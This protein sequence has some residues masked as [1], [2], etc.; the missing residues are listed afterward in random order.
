MDPGIESRNPSIGPLLSLLPYEILV[1]EV[2]GRL[3]I[4]DLAIAS[5]AC[6]KLNTLCQDNK[7]WIPIVLKNVE[8]ELIPI[9]ILK[10]RSF[11]KDF[12]T[13]NP[14]R[15]AV[16]AYELFH[17]VINK[18]LIPDR[19]FIPGEANF[20]LARYMLKHVE[21]FAQRLNINT[22]SHVP[23][24]KAFFSAN[25]SEFNMNDE[26]SFPA[27]IFWIA[28]AIMNY[29]QIAQ[30][31]V[32]ARNNAISSDLKA[33]AHNMYAKFNDLLLE[34]RKEP[35]CID[36]KEEIPEAANKQTVDDE[37]EPDD[38]KLEMVPQEDQLVENEQNPILETLQT[39]LTQNDKPSNQEENP[40]DIA[41]KTAFIKLKDHIEA[42]NKAWADF[43]Q[44]L[45]QEQ[46]SNISWQQ[47]SC[48][49]GE[50]IEGGNL[51]NFY[52]VKSF[53]TKRKWANNYFKVFENMF[54]KMSQRK[55]LIG[56]RDRF[57]N[58]TIA[59]LAKA[60]KTD[61][62]I[63]EVMRIFGHMKDELPH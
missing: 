29:P 52:Q 7:L 38:D 26:G 31:W 30:P 47:L 5:I 45:C 39:Q 57:M 14:A 28:S 40:L 22:N 51:N 55:N 18:D 27:E 6:K 9:G 50:F 58:L 3:S 33:K 16:C 32:I 24:Q 11:F 10:Y 25:L 15:A 48:Y 37:Q 43:I 34:L 44:Q 36:V 63:G 49:R 13:Q 53:E 59:E 23:A 54:S 8:A 19:S 20:E 61:K 2:L 12:I 62:F 60:E 21:L 1:K 56:F 46:R 4:K 17:I 35:L 41:E 42:F